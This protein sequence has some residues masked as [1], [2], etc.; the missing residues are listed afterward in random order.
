MA[1]KTL[2]VSKRFSFSF[3]CCKLN[4]AILVDTRSKTVRT[5]G[6]RVRIQPREVCYHLLCLLFYTV[7]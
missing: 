6:L 1:V 2:G 7:L 4:S 5:L 3:T